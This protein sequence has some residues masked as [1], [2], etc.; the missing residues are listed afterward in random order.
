[1]SE[2]LTCPATISVE[3][4]AD[5]RKILMVGVDDVLHSWAYRLSPAAAAKLGQ[6]LIDVAASLELP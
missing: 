1:M 5:N 2:L 6:Q 3:P 4:T